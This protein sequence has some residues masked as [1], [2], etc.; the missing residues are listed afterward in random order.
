MGLNKHALV[1]EGRGQRWK[2][3]KGKRA[4][5]LP[6]RG[7]ESPRSPHPLWLGVQGCPQHPN[8]SVFCW[9]VA[10]TF[11]ICISL[12]LSLLIW[13]R[14]HLSLQTAQPSNIADFL[15]SFSGIITRPFS[16]SHAPLTPPSPLPLRK[17]ISFPACDLSSSCLM[18]QQVAWAPAAT[19][20]PLP[21]SRVSS[22]PA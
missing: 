11:Q 12:P 17:W 10:P 9:G 18:C 6:E 13:D 21:W 7:G 1:S 15:T 5:V 4:S 3:R 22:S 19:Q 8:C 14:I 20:V 2:E 16:I